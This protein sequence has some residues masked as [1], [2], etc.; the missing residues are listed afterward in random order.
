M[1][2]LY[3]SDQFAVVQI[4]LDPGRPAI[5]A[6]TGTPQAGGYE[7][8]DK[9]ARKE[10]FLGGE[11]A[12]RFREQ[13]DALVKTQPSADEVDAFLGS[14]TGWMHQPLVLH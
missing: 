8:V 6:D 2:M 1:Q 5:A 3:N 14:Y 13:V 11:L 12:A 9:W 10:I 4:D 7:I